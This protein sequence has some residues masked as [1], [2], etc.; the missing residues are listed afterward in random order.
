MEYKS[1]ISDF[2]EIDGRAVTGLAAI[3]GN[4]DLG[5]DRIIKGA[6]K[7]TIKEGMKHIRHLWQHSFRD[8]PVAAIK[9]LKEV[10][11]RELPAGIQDEYPEATGG[12]Q[13]TREYLDTIRGNEVLQGI[14]AGAIKEMSFGFDPIKFDFDEEKKAPPQLVRNLREIRLWDISDVNWGANPATVAVKAAVPFKDTGKDETGAWKA[15]TLG[16]FTSEL[17]AD[18]SSA[19]KSRIAN[20]YAWAEQMPPETF[21]GVK[22]PHH[23]G[24]KSGVGPAV[25]RGVAA[26]MAAMMGARGGVEIP[27]AD[28]KG[29]YNHL[30]KHY[31]Q[32]DKE[33]PAFKFIEAMG[34]I[35]LISEE[36]M[37]NGMDGYFESRVIK[38]EKAISDLREL[39][40][41]AEPLEIDGTDP[42]LTEL[43]LD[44]LDILTRQLDVLGV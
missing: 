37:K 24:G 40:I 43:T 15:P 32:F 17:W 22:L 10:S 30:A 6:F 13:V 12:L 23:R 35:L 9:E 28:R 38:V 39:L 18:M 26:A 25:W 21:G 4:I 16:D 33:P 1:F 36:D 7:K 41:T 14:I 27:T 8:P 29:V 20:H 34:S 44:R 31:A 19:E 2:K 11:R 3:F 5:S 42:A